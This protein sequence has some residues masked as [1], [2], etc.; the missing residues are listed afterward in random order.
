MEYRLEHKSELKVV[1]YKNQLDVTDPAALSN[2]PKLWEEVMAQEEFQ[3]LFSLDAEDLNGLL[4]VW[5]ASEEH[6]VY[7]YY[8]GVATR[9]EFGEKFAKTTLP[10]TDYIVF[11]CTKETLFSTWSTIN[12]GWFNTSAYKR[13]GNN[14]LELY[15]PNDLCEIW[16]PIIT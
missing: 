6:M 11:N 1:G 9:Y 13:L 14:E 4:G 16:I 3:E 2:L 10:E 5:Q 15:L 7:N 8:I 12:E